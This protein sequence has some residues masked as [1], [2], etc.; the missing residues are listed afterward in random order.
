M[1]ENNSSLV[2]YFWNNSKSP[3]SIKGS[4]FIELTGLPMWRPKNGGFQKLHSAWHLIFSWHI[5]VTWTLQ[6]FTENWTILRIPK[7]TKA[8]LQKQ[9][10]NINKRGTVY[11]EKG[12]KNFPTPA[13]QTFSPFFF[14]ICCN[15]ISDV[16]KQYQN[17]RTSFPSVILA[18]IDIEP[19]SRIVSKVRREKKSFFGIIFDTPINFSLTYTRS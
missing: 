11:I 7:T 16:S 19:I 13:F 2:P 17:S 15:P 6:G 9:Q 10:E 3:L 4:G 5:R 8:L 18:I 14:G 12:K 1:T